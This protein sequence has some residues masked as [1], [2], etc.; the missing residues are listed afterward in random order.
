[1]SILAQI[2]KHQLA[3]GSKEK[4]RYS[5]HKRCHHAFLLDRQ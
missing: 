4:N 2:V 3:R 5:E 1:M